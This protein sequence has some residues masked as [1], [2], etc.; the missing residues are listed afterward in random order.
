[1]NSYLPM[2]KLESSSYKPYFWVTFE[3]VF[4]QEISVP[5]FSKHIW[6]KTNFDKLLKENKYEWHDANWHVL[7]VKK[8]LPDIA[9]CYTAVKYKTQK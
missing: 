8:N 6:F 5:K 2:L 9:F 4:E 1:M 3:K 7:K